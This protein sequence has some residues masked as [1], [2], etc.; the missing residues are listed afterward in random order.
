MKKG[1]YV[2]RKLEVFFFHLLCKLNFK[3]IFFPLSPF[4]LS[5]VKNPN[6]NPEQPH[7]CNRVF[8]KLPYEN[9]WRLENWKKFEIIKKKPVF[10]RHF[11]HIPCPPSLFF[12][13]LKQGMIDHKSATLVCSTRNS[14]FLFRY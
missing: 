1:F 14:K 8:P 7:S 5:V 13:F 4:N 6:A 2:K 10:Q 12:F 11:H 9:N 3:S